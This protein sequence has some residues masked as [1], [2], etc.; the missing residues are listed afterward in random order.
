MLR[1]VSEPS[2]CWSTKRANAQTT[3]IPFYIS[4]CASDTACARWISSFLL[5]TREYLNRF[6]ILPE[7]FPP[8]VLTLLQNN[9]SFLLTVFGFR[10]VEEFG[11]VS[12]LHK[13]RRQ[14]SSLFFDSV[15][16]LM[17]GF[18]PQL[19]LSKMLSS[20]V[21]QSCNQR[22]YFSQC[23]SAVTPTLSV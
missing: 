13:H 16:F 8:F 22:F 17:S 10:C 6:H 7:N 1:P 23:S 15:L 2:F 19:L 18:R 21:S 3:K 9:I 11:L 4:V 20:N 14:T 5:S 12:C